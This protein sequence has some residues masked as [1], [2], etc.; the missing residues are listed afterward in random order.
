[1]HSG[2]L[3]Q[4][5]KLLSQNFKPLKVNALCKARIYAPDV[6]DATY[7]PEIIF[8]SLIRNN[9]HM[10]NGLWNLKAS[11]V[12]KE[13]MWYGYAKHMTDEFKEDCKLDLIM[14]KVWEPAQKLWD[15]FCQEVESGK[16]TFKRTDE[17]FGA[18]GKNYIGI[19]KELHMT[20]NRQDVVQERL[21]Q[22]RRYHRLKQCIRG[23]H[24]IIKLRDNFGLSGDF[25]IPEMLANIVSF[26]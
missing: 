20:G 16:L 1:M 25:S 21:E 13:F 18:F 12:F 14:T 11:V 17:L 5:R 26:C 15:L 2:E 8:F 23:A 4:L 7:N 19:E 9:I 10:L 3:D 24:M 6:D 22:I